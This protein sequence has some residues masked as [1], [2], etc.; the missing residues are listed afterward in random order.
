MSMAV[1]PCLA[2]IELRRRLLTPDLR[3]AQH[4]AQVRTKPGVDALVEICAQECTGYIEAPQE[5]VEGYY[6]SRSD[7][8]ERL[9]LL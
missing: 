6:S 8:S 9:I 7:R 3:T 5:E 4:R 2:C 1:L